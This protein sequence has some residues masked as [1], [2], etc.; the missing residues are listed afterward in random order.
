MLYFTSPQIKLFAQRH[1][2]QP[3]IST[4]Y[5][6]KAVKGDDAIALQ[7]L[8]EFETKASLS[9][10]LFSVQIIFPVLS[11]VGAFLGIFYIVYEHGTLIEEDATSD[12]DRRW[13]MRTR[14]YAIFILTVTFS[15]YCL[16]MSILGV[17]GKGIDTMLDRDELKWLASIILIEDIAVFILM[18]VCTILVVVF[19]AS[20]YDTMLFQW[21]YILYCLGF[22]ATN[23]AIHANHILI[24]FIQ[25]SVYAS[26]VA[27][28]YGILVI[29]NV[30]LMRFVGYL[31]KQC[32]I[33]KEINLIMTVSADLVQNNAVLAV[34][35]TIDRMNEIIYDRQ[36]CEQRKKQMVVIG[37]T[38]A[39]GNLSL[40][41]GNNLLEQKYKIVGDIGNQN[42]GNQNN[43]NQN[44]GNQNNGNQ[45]NGNQNNGNQNNG[46]Q[47]N[48]NQNNGNQNNGNQ[49]NVVT[50]EHSEDLD[51]VTRVIYGDMGA[52][53]NIVRPKADHEGFTIIARNGYTIANNGA[54]ST[55]N[56]NV[57]VPG[58]RLVIGKSDNY[59]VKFIKDNH[60]G[61][62]RLKLEA[63]YSVEPN[64]HLFILNF[65]LFFPSCVFLDLLFA[66]FIGLFIIVP[67]NNAFESALTQVLTVY[68]GLVI[69][70]VGFLAYWFVVKPDPIK[71]VVLPRIVL[72]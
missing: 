39:G 14:L 50:I 24:A 72:Y 26:S 54:E 2:I 70:L 10:Y 29:L 69:I 13:E 35:G 30:L 57:D 20:K 71:K 11:A 45:N 60:L 23:L 3:L 41:Y 9:S 22:L 18:L 64:W 4:D 21:K 19:Y 47:N 61:E 17:W 40:K 42:N 59:A 34:S 65:C 16:I 31:Y 28:S 33:K 1:S 68:Q 43:G 46:N 58:L 25:D 51:I 7:L 53:I 37:R 6:A 27:I 48:G 5:N 62:N 55:A 12:T 38:A 52:T 15:M 66:Y 63:K 56:D 36:V 8:I 67:I 32:F 49:N 44:N